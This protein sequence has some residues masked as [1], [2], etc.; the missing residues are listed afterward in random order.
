MKVSYNSGNR[1]TFNPL[2][3]GGTPVSTTHQDLANEAVVVDVIVNDDHPEYANDGYNIGAIKFRSIKSDMYRGNM[4]LHW[5]LPLDANVSEY[6]LL[7]EVV[8][9]HTVLNRMYYSRKINTTSRVTTHAI[10]GLNEE[11]S[12]VISQTQRSEN[13]RKHTSE[14]KER[15]DISPKLGKYFQ[16]MRGIYRLRHDE[17]DIVF[18]GRS[19]QSIRFGAAWRKGS[20]FVA[21]KYD[22]SPN[23]ILRAG[24]DTTQTPSVGQNGL[25]REDVNK[26]ASSVYIVSDQTVPLE[27]ATKK[28]AVHAKSIVDFPSKLTGAQIV[29]NSD[30][31]VVNAK[32][33]TIMGFSQSGIHWT[34]NK[35]FTVDAGNDY[36]SQ[37]MRDKRV[38]IGRD[39][40]FNVGN[41]YHLTAKTRISLQSPKVYI[42]LEENDSQPIACGAEL[43]EFLGKFLDAFISNGYGISMTTGTPGTPSPLNPKIIQALTQLKVDVSKGALASFNSSIAYTTK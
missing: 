29:L 5:A 19:G 2:Y 6:P 36:K 41:V 11:L 39:S 20:M 34:T 3:P 30:R 7:S 25:V 35:D 22:Q 32:T 17:G 12:P 27:Y 33:S 43:A 23:I 16:D 18:E 13:F 37:I 31:V 40:I 26:D 28:G 15:G 14:K 38:F 21:N 24:A 8:Q 9:I 4:D 10:P 42:G 1:G